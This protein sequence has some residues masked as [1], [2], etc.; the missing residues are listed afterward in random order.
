MLTNPFYSKNK[1]IKFQNELLN[2]LSMGSKIFKIKLIKLMHI[3][4]FKYT[5]YTEFVL[6]HVMKFFV[7]NYLHVNNTLSYDAQ[8][9]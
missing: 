5:V 9:F 6:N 1:K 7:I 8:Q 3:F 2:Q 4:Y